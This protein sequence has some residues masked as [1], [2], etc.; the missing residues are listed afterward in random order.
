MPGQGK[1]PSDT[2]SFLEDHKDWGPLRKD[3]P[4]ILFQ[5][6][7]PKP[8]VDPDNKVGIL[9]YQGRVVL[10]WSGQPVKEFRELP[11]TISSH[12]EGWRLEAILRT[13]SKIVL[14]DILSRMISKQQG[15]T[16]KGD[17]I[18]KG[19]ASYI[20]ISGLSMRMDRWRRIG[21]CIQWNRQA[22]DDILKNH[23]L[24][25]MTPE[26]KEKNTTEGLKDIVRGSGERDYLEL[27]KY[28]SQ[29]EK[30]KAEIAD[31]VRKHVKDDLQNKADKWIKNKAQ[32]KK[33]D[34]GRAEPSAPKNRRTR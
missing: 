23:I 22:N 16:G 17:W 24:S 28:G 27:I 4:K 2:T 9:T 10:D 30:R 20:S 5:L 32:N 3:R 7:P 14:N 1:G 6:E 34:A 33:A 26:M 8:R 15:Q 21:R 11:F 29:P 19:D 12:V 13:N 31:A 18:H 25:L